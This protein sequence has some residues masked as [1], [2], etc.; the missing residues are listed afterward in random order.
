MVTRPHRAIGSLALFGALLVAAI[1]VGIAMATQTFRDRELANS[2][3]EL[4]NT[5]LILAEQT[6]R[7]IQSLDLVL[8]SVIERMQSIGIS[9]TEDFQRRMSGQDVQ[10]LLKDKISG[11]PHI[12]AVS[13]FDTDGKM[14]NL[15]RFWPVPNLNNADRNYFLAFKSDPKL[16]SLISE[17]VINRATGTWTMFLVRRLTDPNGKVLRVINGAMQLTFYEK[18]FGAVVLNEHSDISL[19]HSDGTLLARYPRIE[20]A[21][22]AVFT[23][24]NN[25]LGEQGSGTARLI[26]KMD[27]KDRLLAAHRLSHYPLVIAVTTD[28][29]AALASWRNERNLLIGAGAFSVLAITIVFLLIVR[30]SSRGH[31]WSKQRLASEKLRLD[32]PINNMSQGLLLFDASERIVIC[33]QRYIR[34]YGLSPD[35]V[36]PGCTF[37]DLILHRKQAGTFTGDIDGYRASLMR[38]LAQGKASELL[39]ETPDGRSI[40][41]VNQPLANGG[42][43]ATHEDIT[44]ARSA[45]Q[46]RDRNRKFLDLIIDNVPTT[47]I[48]KD[49]RSRQF[50]LINQAGEAHL[51]ASRDQ[52]IGKTAREVRP[53]QIADMIEEQD[54]QLLASDGYLLFNE[55]TV[56]PSGN[57]HRVVTSKKL[58]IPDDKGEPQYFLSVIEDVTERKRSEERIA[59]LA[60]YD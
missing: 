4:K 26:G 18:L 17:P 57:N 60:H 34:M 53:K 25:A 52:M 22:G 31:R 30:Q 6:D 7:T 55:H 40:R 42:W 48:V 54:Q 19:A 45:E 33:N 27:G 5:A 1:V 41:I 56:N 43:V 50:V 47:I 2:E 20:T 37:R 16:N 32:T 12:D 38:D 44:Q 3:R 11:L 14:I 49:A 51:G 28:V 15:S 9:S 39:L 21:I 13:L 58:I 35:V 36:R 8:T 29:D 46:E 10:S 24:A 23:G 59:H